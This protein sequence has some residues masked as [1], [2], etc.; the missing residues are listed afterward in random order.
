[1]RGALQE[2]REEKR[3]ERERCVVACSLPV[4]AMIASPRY[5][6]K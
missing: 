2:K 5:L 3:R 1:M 4:I 6:P